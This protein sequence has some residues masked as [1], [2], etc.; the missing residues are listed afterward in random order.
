MAIELNHLTNANIYIN[1]NSQLGR[2][3]EFKLPTVK[4]KMVEHKAVGLVGTLKLP[5]GIEEMEGE[6][7]WNAFY[8]SVWGQILDPFAPVM[9]QARGSLETYSS[10]GRLQEVP[11]VVFVTAAFS[12]VPAGDFKQNDKA[13]FSSKFTASYIKLVV[14]GADVLEVDVAANIYKVNGIDK[15]ANY[16]K[17]IGG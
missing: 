9:L 4:F 14:D 1:G 2:A 8:Q 6:I 13:E 5:A 17:N 3:E 7:K 16:R 10:Q 11:Y 12:E 15:L